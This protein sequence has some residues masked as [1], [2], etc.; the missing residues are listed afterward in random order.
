MYFKSEKGRFATY[1]VN[2]HMLDKNTDTRMYANISIREQVGGFGEG[3]EPKYEFQTWSAVFLG[4]KCVEKAA[5][6]PS[7]TT[8]LLKAIDFRNHYDKEREKSYPEIHVLDFD[9]YQKNENT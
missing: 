5:S 9:V 6:V 7:K 2:E 3:E 1:Y 4:K 8:I